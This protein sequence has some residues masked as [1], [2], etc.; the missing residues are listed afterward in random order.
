MLIGILVLG[1]CLALI[2]GYD[3]RLAAFVLYD[4]MAI[5][6]WAAHAPMS[7]FPLINFGESAILYCFVFL[8]IA[9]AGPGP[10]SID[11]QQNRR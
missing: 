4:A 10:W 2:G 1:G 9:A 11:A 6:Y 7:F 3:T 5:A 8:Y